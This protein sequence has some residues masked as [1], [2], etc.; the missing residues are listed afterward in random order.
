MKEGMTVP[1][2]HSGPDETWAP[3]DLLF[4]SDHV[5]FTGLRG[6]SLYVASIEGSNVKNLRA[7]FQGE[8]GRLRTVV[9]GPDGKLY[10]LTSNRDG[11]G[12][13]EESD[14]RVIKIDPNFLGLTDF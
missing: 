4:I 12:S 13:S 14:D 11:R 3:G 10:V 5:V 6:E 8:Y 7:F 1:I 9:K 2:L